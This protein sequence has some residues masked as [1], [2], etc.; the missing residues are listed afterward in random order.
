MA[1]KKAPVG[2]SK[3]KLNPK[4]CIP[5]KESGPAATPSPMGMTSKLKLSEG[6]SE[7]PDRSQPIDEFGYELIQK[8]PDAGSESSDSLVEKSPHERGKTPESRKK[9]KEAP[10]HQ[11]PPVRRT[12]STV[13]RSK[14]R[15]EL[16]SRRRKVILIVVTVSAFIIGGFFGMGVHFYV[17][18]SP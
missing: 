11:P 1:A 5:K 14:K 17:C 8:A 3:A 6:L 9:S 16:A 15:R 4:A 10:E 12:R 18:C 2:L 13:V 7:M